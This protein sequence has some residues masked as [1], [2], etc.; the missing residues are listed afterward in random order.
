VPAMHKH[1]SP[2]AEILA[3]S[4][5]PRVDPQDLAQ[6]LAER[7]ARLAADTRTDCEKFLGDPAPG[8]SALAGNGDAACVDRRRRK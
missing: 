1:R 7:D 2:V 4:S 3:L 8:R 5:G 6:R